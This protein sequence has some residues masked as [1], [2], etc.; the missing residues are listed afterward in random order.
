MP[1]YAFNTY[2]DKGGHIGEFSGLERGSGGIT[3]GIADA[4]AGGLAFFSG[5]TVWRPGTA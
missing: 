1:L 4:D 5:V 2:T 3:F